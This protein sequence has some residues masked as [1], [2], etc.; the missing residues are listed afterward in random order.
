MELPPGAVLTEVELVHRLGCGR[1]PLR[2]ALQRLSE[3][4][5]VEITPRQGIRIA[6]MNLVEYIKLID[7]LA[8]LEGN[9]AR[10]AAESITPEEIIQLEEMVDQAQSHDKWGD[11]LALADHDY[12]F[13]MIIA[14]AGRNKYLADA[15][16]R[17][18]SLAARYV[19]LATKNGAS[20]EPSIG[21]HRQILGLLTGHN[22]AESEKAMIAHI[23]KAKDRI[24][25]SI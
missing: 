11:A 17:I 3:Q 5:L 21:E 19:F 22:P 7:A 16:N 14:R 10:M 4:Y 12:Q 2:E 20:D 23:Y 24:L 25:N 9:S 1:T 18:H 8:V 6:D 15:V 13:H